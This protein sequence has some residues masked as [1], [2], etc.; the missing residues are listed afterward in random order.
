M[1]ETT[2]NTAK[3]DA[4]EAL[5][6]KAHGGEIHSLESILR[7]LPEADQREAWRI[8]YGDMPEPLDIPAE[9]QALAEAG[10]FD[11]AL[12][13]FHAA[14]EQRRKPRIVRVGVIQNQIVASTSDSVEDQ[15]QALADR[16]GEMIEAA[17]Q[18]GVNVLC[19][20]EAWTM[21]FA[22]CTREKQPW[23]EFAEPVDGPS[24]QFLA[25]L[26][27]E[28]NMVIVSPILER[29]EAHG[30]TIHNTAVV[31]GNRGNVIGSH[32]KN[33]IPRVGDFNESTYYMEGDNGHPVFATEFGNV[34]INIC[35]G[36]HHPLNWLMFGLNGAEI[37]FNPSATVGALSEPL[38]PIEARC[39]A[40]ANNYFTA[41]I[42]RIGTETFPNK[43]TS[44]NGKEA[45][46][47]F[48]H[49]YGSSYVGAPNGART[50]GLSRI[51]DGL[52]V[53]EI[54]LN[55]CRQ[56]KDV[57]GFQMTMRLEEYAKRLAEAARP[58]FVPQIIRDPGA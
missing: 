9:V 7:K 35:Y 27:K 31:I 13:K 19:L 15:Y 45:H 30:G 4:I 33:H 2:T 8:L 44:G 34:A 28:H 38:W 1:S 29:D 48:G 17:G 36:R 55:H 11:V 16:V 40:I 6:S 18:L 52:L 54:D 10:N 20:Q 23:L 25:A 46:N 37:V 26:A 49:F 12:H 3:Y 43:F 56:V 53:A 41:N 24:T 21:P 51:K 57:W 42:N 5:L 22:F 58:D 14:P 39:A 32:R 50:P 47:D